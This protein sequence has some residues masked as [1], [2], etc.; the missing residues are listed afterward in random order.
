MVSFFSKKNNKIIVR[1][2]GGLG[3]QMFQY[4]Y[5]LILSK[6]LNREIL[7]DDFILR[8]YPLKKKF[9]KRNFE[10]NIY[11]NQY[12]FFIKDFLNG[13]PKRGYFYSFFSKIK[14][15][16]YNCYLITDSNIPSF[17]E[18]KRID[19]N[20]YLS[21]I[22][23][24]KIDYSKY[25][26][27]IIDFFSSKNI[28]NK[29]LNFSNSIKDLISKSNS[30]SIHVRRGDY[31]KKN[32]LQTHGLCTLDYYRKA[33][34]YFVDKNSNINFFIFSDDLEWCKN[35]FNLTQNIFY[36]EGSPLDD[37]VLMS[38]CKNNIIANSSFSWWSA[39]LNQNESKI[40]IYP[41]NWFTNKDLKIYTPDDWIMI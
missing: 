30:V 17:N 5:A 41:Q 12:N 26:K 3:N 18:L 36:C 39:F 22:F 33:I 7:I 9:T 29:K 2:S 34:N 21:G 6:K 24:E 27:I 16:F 4:S 20:I 32:N 25:K 28:I 35:N 8:D 38:L 1:L 40:V 13:I 14:I 15:I 19:K 31:L 23:Q 11:K 37:F 10:L